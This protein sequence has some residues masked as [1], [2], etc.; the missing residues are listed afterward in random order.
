MTSAWCLSLFGWILGWVWRTGISP[1][2]RPAGQ[3]FRFTQGG[4]LMT[5]C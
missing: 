1:K 2:W 5:H 3:L 4:G